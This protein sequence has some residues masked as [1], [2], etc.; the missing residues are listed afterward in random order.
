[1]ILPAIQNWTSLSIS[2][3]SGSYM[4]LKKPEVTPAQPKSVRPFSNHPCSGKT[5]C[6][7]QCLHGMRCA[8]YDQDGVHQN[9]RNILSICHQNPKGTVHHLQFQKKWWNV[10]NLHYGPTAQKLYMGSDG[11]WTHY[12]ADFYHVW[13]RQQEGHAM[14]ED[15]TFG[16]GDRK[17]RHICIYWLVC[18][19]CVCLCL[20]FTGG[21]PQ[22]FGDLGCLFPFRRKILKVS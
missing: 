6:G 8:V 14:P 13:G 7:Q 1:M 3:A 11:Y 20:P 19:M 4:Q 18:C 5:T 10:T 2:Q 22:M 16:A 9:W 15:K 17:T 12:H 21:F